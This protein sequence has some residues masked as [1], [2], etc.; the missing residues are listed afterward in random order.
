MR[1]QDLE[2]LHGILAA[3]GGFGHREHLELAWR[4]LERYPAAEA[5]HAM[6]SAIRHLASLHG[7]A[8]KYHETIT[9][10]WVYLV[11][12]HRAGGDARSFDEFI[13]ENP[14]LTDRHLLDAHYSPELIS[15]PRARTGWAQ[16]DR[17]ELPR[18][19]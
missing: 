11:A 16:P 18:V 10:C 6:C 1:E 8:D 4:L 19:A 2:I 9:R 12:L 13:A 15:S 14:G 5:Q 7:A 3:R 17:R